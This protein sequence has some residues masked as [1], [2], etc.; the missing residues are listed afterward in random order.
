MCRLCRLLP[1]SSSG[2]PSRSSTFRFQVVEEVIRDVFKVFPKDG[3]QQRLPPSVFLVEVLAVFSQ[4][5]ALQR[6]VPPRML[7]FRLVEVV[8]IFPQDRF[9]LRFLELNMFM[10]LMDMELCMVHSEV[11]ELLLVLKALS[12]T[13]F[14]SSSC[15]CARAGLR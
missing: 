1:F 10:M 13:E 14:N 7:T 15:G 12:E 5:R 4:D 9:Q 8:K 11:E 2:L 6:L 3:V